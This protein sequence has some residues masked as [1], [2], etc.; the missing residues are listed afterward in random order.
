MILGGDPTKPYDAVFVNAPLKDYDFQP[1]HNDF[2]LPVLG[3]GYIATF[4]ASC[5]H[6]VGVL[7]AEANG[8][9]PRSIAAAIN[10]V[11]PRWVGFNLLAP[12]YHLAVRT[13]QLLDSSIAVLV[14]GHQ[15]KAM[16]FQILSDNAFP[17]I[18]ALILGEGE[19]RTE[20][21]LRDYDIRGHLPGVMF[22]SQ[23][24]EVVTATQREPTTH[25]GSWTAPD[26]N[27]LPFVDRT[28]F[29]QDPFRSSTGV[30]ESN[31]VGS[32]GCPY[33]CSFCGAAKSAN[34]D[35]TI[36]TRTPA[37][38]I[39][40]LESLNAAF[41]VTAFRF[42][43]DLFLANL[44]FMKK[45]LPQ[46]IECGIGRRFQWDATGRINVLAK[47]DESMFELMKQAG[48]REVALG[49]ESGSERVLGY[50]D[51]HVTPDMTLK[52]V[53]RLTSHGIGVKGYII[54]GFPTETYSELMETYEHVQK[55]WKIADRNIGTFRCSVFEFRPYP[56]TPE[57]ERLIRS[58]RYTEA[59]L[60]NYEHVDLTAG[61]SAQ[62]LLDRDEFN[63]SV[64]IQFGETPLSRIRELLTD[65]TCK[66]KSRLL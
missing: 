14:G 37:N 11:K 17:R 28:Y 41:T 23:S 22:R 18:D 27:A 12:T 3:L 39:A 52:A 32:R 50:I 35:I 7:D 43:D 19:Y 47:A 20:A 49:I 42:V 62:A 34:P 15:A 44:N 53:D 26:I 61:G 59:D 25:Q 54:M 5:G 66:Q 46:F 33:D 56:G 58:G 51:K 16:P 2:T 45:C 1:R 64:N 38:L 21:I 65:L 40:E 13:A 63:F 31:I 55:L 8:L 24:G 57:W 36:R 9:G 10:S 4:A 29:V 6:N 30:L 48:C 60:L